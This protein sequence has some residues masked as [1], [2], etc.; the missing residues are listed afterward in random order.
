MKIHIFYVQ[1]CNL[2][3]SQ[4]SHPS[5]CGDS[6]LRESVVPLH[7]CKDA[8]HIPPNDSS[9]VAAEGANHKSTRRESLMSDHD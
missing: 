5:H 2:H 8:E 4:L 7:H 9:L 3:D 6:M 1:D